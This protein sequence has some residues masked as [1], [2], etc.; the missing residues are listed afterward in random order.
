MREVLPLFEQVGFDVVFVGLV[1]VFTFWLLRGLATNRLSRVFVGMKSGL[2]EFDEFLS[3]RKKASIAGFVIGAAGVGTVFN[4][5][6][7]EILDSDSVM[8]AGYVPYVPPA[9]E[10]FSPDAWWTGRWDEEDLLKVQALK[11]VIE[12]LDM[13]IEVKQALC[14]HLGRASEHCP[15]ADGQAKHD[16][17][18]ALTKGL[19]QHAFA[20]IAARGSDRVNANLRWRVT[21]IKLLQVLFVSSVL[22]LGTMILAPLSRLIFGAPQL[23][24]QDSPPKRAFLRALVAIV[25]AWLVVG[26]SVRLWTEFSL[27]HYKKTLHAYVY[28]LADGDEVLGIPGKSGDD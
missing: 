3:T 1:M 22:V 25:A 18:D 19:F 2:D 8:S 24:D 7:D 12:R 23:G 10:F 21:S 11:D 5:I 26:A 17:G 15:P 27:A 9:D 20:T 13:K 14:R 16:T 4:V 6:A 28:L